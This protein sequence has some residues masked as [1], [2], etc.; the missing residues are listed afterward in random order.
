MSVPTVKIVNAKKPDEFLI[1]NVSDFNPAVHV[2]WT[3]APVVAPVVEAPA[4]PAANAID[5]YDI[6]VAP[7]PR[8]KRGR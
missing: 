3:G 8:G 4:P 7:A 1:I 5:A 6:P 2:A